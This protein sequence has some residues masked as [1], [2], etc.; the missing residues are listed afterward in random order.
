MLTSEKDDLTKSTPSAI[1]KERLKME[2][3]HNTDL[4]AKQRQHIDNMESLKRQLE[5]ETRTLR[6]QLDQQHELKAVLEK[7]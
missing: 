2:Q 4:E 6:D 1:E 7:V 5:G 3:L